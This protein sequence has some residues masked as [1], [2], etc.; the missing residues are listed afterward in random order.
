VTAYKA[1]MMVATYCYILHICMIWL[2]LYP[3]RSQAPDWLVALINSNVLRCVLGLR[4][5]DV[6]SLRPIKN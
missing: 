4:F 3:P 1:V 5:A 6:S 2:E